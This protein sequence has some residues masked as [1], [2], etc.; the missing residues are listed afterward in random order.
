MENPLFVATKYRSIFFTKLKLFSHRI[1]ARIVFFFTGLVLFKRK[2]E[3]TQKDILN[4]P[5]KL[6][7]GD[8]ILSSTFSDT[9]SLFIPGAVTH[10]ALYVGRR[11]VIHAIGSGVQY[12]TLHDLLA[13]YDTFAILRL[14]RKTKGKRRIIRKTVRFAKQQIGKPY[15]FE[16]HPESG[17]FFCSELVNRAYKEAGHK[18]KLKNFEAFRPFIGRIERIITSARKA[19]LPEKFILSHFRIIFL[20]HNLEIKKRELIL[21][22]V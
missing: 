18:T 10:S 8:I 20:S 11:R 17:K 21:K 6:R 5:L 1:L 22:T 3:L 16:D 13:T 19:L 12:A 9:S 7:T 15:G 4:I 2:N 14:P